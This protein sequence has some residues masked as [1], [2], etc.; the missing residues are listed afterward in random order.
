MRKLGE[1]IELVLVLTIF[2]VAA[3]LAVYA[4]RNPEATETQR[5]LHFWDALTFKGD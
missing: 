3:A 4:F 2:Y 1:A 5:L